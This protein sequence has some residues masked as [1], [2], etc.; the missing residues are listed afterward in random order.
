MNEQL[1]SM[2]RERDQAN[3]KVSQLEAYVKEL[4]QKHRIEIRETKYFSW[5][6]KCLRQAYYHCCGGAAY[7]SSDCQLKDW[8]DHSRKCTRAADDN[9]KSSKL[10]G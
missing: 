9:Q 1:V 6:L 2:G 5:C 7:C 10:P 4:T 8:P 3:A